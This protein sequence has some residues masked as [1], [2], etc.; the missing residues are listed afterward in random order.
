VKLPAFTETGVPVPTETPLAK[1]ARDLMVGDVG[2]GA[3]VEVRP[4]PPYKAIALPT[5]YMEPLPGKS[6]EI[7]VTAGFGRAAGGCTGGV[8][9]Q[10]LSKRL[11]VQN[12]TTIDLVFMMNILSHS[13]HFL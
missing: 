7:V 4:T 12:K 1:N 11:I 10:A 3:N 9:P 13:E 2:L 6:M 5:E 8:P